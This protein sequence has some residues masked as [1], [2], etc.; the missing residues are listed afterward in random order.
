MNDRD[1][2][3]SELSVWLVIGPFVLA[4]CLLGCSLATLSGRF[5]FD[6]VSSGGH[7]P[8]SVENQKK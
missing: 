2:I 5:F 7:L 1:H 6:V 4:L 3:F 8:F